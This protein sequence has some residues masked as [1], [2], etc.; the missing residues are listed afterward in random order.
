[1]EEKG[2]ISKLP[3]NVEK[4]EIPP[5]R[6]YAYVYRVKVFKLRLI[7]RKMEKMKFKQICVQ[8]NGG[9]TRNLLL[10]TRRHLSEGSA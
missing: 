5:G 2:D 8:K 4:V 6:A 9:D 7:A 3:R 1:M 10:D